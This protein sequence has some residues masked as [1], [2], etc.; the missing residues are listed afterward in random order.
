M[1]YVIRFLPRD[2]QDPS[3]PLY[4]SFDRPADGGRRLTSVPQ[5]V[6]IF[7]GT[8]SAHVAAL[9]PSV[10]RAAMRDR[11]L[12]SAVPMID[13]LRDLWDAQ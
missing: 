11:L 6:E 8:H 9:S 2:P 7:S 12:I 10:V 1:G 4:L 5:D 3:P 13:A